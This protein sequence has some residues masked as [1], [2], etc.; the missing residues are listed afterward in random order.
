[1][2]DRLRTLGV[3]DVEQGDA[4]AEG[5]ADVGVAAVDHDL[6]T[7][8]AP[9]LIGVADELDVPGRD[10]I[11]GNGCL[12][13]SPGS[14]PSR[15]RSV[16]RRRR[17]SPPMVS[18]RPAPVS[19]LPVV[20][21]VLAALALGACATAPPPPTDPAQMPAYVGAHGRFSKPSGPGPFPTV[22]VMHGCG[23]PPG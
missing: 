9:A 1:E 13:R 6:H 21:H 12:P 3:A 8:A 4:V 14:A 19:R 17:T 18:S 23:G 2:L 20:A 10:R 11:H 5:V 7:V 16:S 15:S 22:V